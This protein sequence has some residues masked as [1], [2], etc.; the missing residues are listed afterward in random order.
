MTKEKIQGA[1]YTRRYIYNFHYHLIWVTKYRNQT[2]ATKELAD[3]MKSILQK[4][5]DDN[6]IVIEKMEVMPDHVHVLIS[7]PPSKAPTSAIKALKGRSAFIFLKRHP[8]IRHSQ[9][10]GGHLWSPSYYM[11][12]LGNM[13][14]DVVENYINNQKYNEL[15]KRPKRR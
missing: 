6:K 5:A 12:T 14:K 13:S 15:T 8:E 3:E 9:D 7:F 11:S 4:V 10:W 2:F 1:V